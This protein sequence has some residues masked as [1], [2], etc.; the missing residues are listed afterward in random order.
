[1]PEILEKIKTFVV[2]IDKN[3]L[4]IIFL[5][6]ACY[7]I[8]C[9]IHNYLIKREYKREN[10][11]NDKRFETKRCKEDGDTEKRKNIYLIDK[12]STPKTYQWIMDPYTFKELGYGNC[13]K[14]DKK[15]FSKEDKNYVI[16]KRIKIC[17]MIFNVK[18][19]LKL[20]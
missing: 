3:L 2:F 9:L 8:Y 13:S 7:F 5:C 6:L 17:N 12:E 4:G 16:K 19:I 18:E 11:N 15:C 10:N 20:K 1:M 14:E